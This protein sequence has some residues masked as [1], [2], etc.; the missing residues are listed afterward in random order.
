MPPATSLNIA[1]LPSFGTSS[2]TST[3]YQHQSNCGFHQT[4]SDWII[5]S[6]ATDHMTY[7]SNDFSSVAHPRRSM[8]V[9]TNGVQYPVTGAGIVVLSSSL[10]LPDTLLIPSL[11]NKLL[12]VSQ[13]TTDLKCVVLMYPTFCILQDIVTKEII[14]RG[15]R[16]GGLYYM[17]DF[18]Q[19]RANQMG[20]SHNTNDQEI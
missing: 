16:R 4:S 12:S 18:S 15:T 9:N 17:D 19:S 2:S 10:S 20:S 1:Q 13:I 11:S 5:D 8:I 3:T 7:D 6:G 14:S